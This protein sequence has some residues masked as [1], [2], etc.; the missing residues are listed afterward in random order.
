VSTTALQLLGPSAGGIRVHVATLASGLE[1]LGVAA[2]VVGPAGVLAGLGVQAGEVPVPAG[3]SPTG[4][5][6]ARRALAE[7]RPACDLVHAHGL[8]AAWT[9]VGGRPRRP[10]VLTVHNVVLDAS[11]G[12]WAEVQ[13]RLERAVLRSADRV[14]ALTSTMASELSDVVPESRLRVVLPA[15]PPPSVTRGPD[16]VRSELGVPAGAPLVVCAARLHP[17]KDLP[18]LLRA[19]QL[20]ARRHPDA[21]LRVLGDGPLH[22]ELDELVER[23]GVG[24]SAR[25][26]GRVPGAVDHLA[27]ADI[28]V[29]TSLWEG[30]SIV[31]AESTR[32]GVPVVSTPTGMAPDLLDGTRGGVIVPVGDHEAVAAALVDLLDHPERAREL[33]ERGRAHAEEVFD[34][35]RAVQAVADVYREVT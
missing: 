9:S 8:K 34:T 20:V 27:A 14:I 5:W 23:L 32:L 30:A 18:T 19:W 24:A 1:E 28:S 35:R 29:M 12:R 15:S 16:E 33:G 2:P 11:A 13:R 7:W 3:M 10:V 17:Q 26:V 31:L 4:L 21:Q 6:R 25:L 22:A